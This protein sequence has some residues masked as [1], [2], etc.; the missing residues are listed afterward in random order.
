VTRYFSA[1]RGPDVPVLVVTTTNWQL[2][3]IMASTGD[4]AALAEALASGMAAY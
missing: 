1:L 2:D 4:A 3:G